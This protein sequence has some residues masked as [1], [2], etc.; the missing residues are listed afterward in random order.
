MASMVWFQYVF[1]AITLILLARSALGRMNFKAWMAFVP[2]LVPFACGVAD[3][4]FTGESWSTMVFMFVTPL[5]QSTATLLMS[6]DSCRDFF[7]LWRRESL[8]S[9]LV[10]KKYID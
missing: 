6:R 2:L 8:P 5:S 10:T 4:C 7:G 9:I 1:A 3:S